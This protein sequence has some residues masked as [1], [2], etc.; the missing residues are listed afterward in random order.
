M[1][2]LT[3]L[4]E[5]AEARVFNSVLI[6]GLDAG[7]SVA[8]SIDASEPRDLYVRLPHS[9]SIISKFEPRNKT[10]VNV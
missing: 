6:A 7:P 4:S 8:R 5:L 10:E 1:E 2:E 3:D 9:G